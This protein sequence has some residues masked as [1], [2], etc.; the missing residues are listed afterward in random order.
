MVEIINGTVGSHSLSSGL[1]TFFNCSLA[2]LVYI[3]V[4]L[5]L[6]CPN[7]DWIYLIFVP[8]SSKCV[9]YECLKL[10]GVTCLWMPAATAASLTILWIVSVERFFP[11]FLLNTN[12]LWIF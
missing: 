8:A 3:W 2:T 1:S 11:F 7:N 10:C 4:V 5:R 12:S 6:L 9:A